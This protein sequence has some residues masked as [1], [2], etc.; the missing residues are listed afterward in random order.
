MSEFHTRPHWVETSPLNERL[1][2]WMAGFFD[3]EGCVHQKNGRLAIEANVAQ[4]HHYILE[5]FQK[6]FGGGIYEISP[7]GCYQWMAPKENSVR[8][9]KAVLPYLT[10]KL[11]EAVIALTLAARPNF[12][13]NGSRG[14]PPEEIEIRR[15]LQDALQS[16][17]GPRAESNA[18][19]GTSHLTPEDIK[20]F[21]DELI[22]ELDA[23]QI[24]Y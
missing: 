12:Q 11:D 23:M 4:K 19:V 20:W 7:V 16:Y 18:L 10:I 21:H 22:K 3:G 2:I 9:L 1:L 8:F 13:G 14:V 15:R 17:K 24:P 6:H 5:V